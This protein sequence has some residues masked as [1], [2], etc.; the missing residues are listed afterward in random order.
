MTHRDIDTFAS[1]VEQYR[2]E[3]D[4][5]LEQIA[6]VLAALAS[7]DTPLLLT[8]AD[9]PAGFADSEGSHDHSRR[10][11]RDRSFGRERRDENTGCAGR[12]S[13]EGRESEKMETFRIEVGHAHKVKPANIVGAI[14]NET[15]LES[16]L[17]GRIEIF[18]EHS[19]VDMLAGMPAKIFDVLKN[20][21]IGG[22]RLDI[23]RLADGASPDDWPTVASVKA[24]APAPALPLK[25]ETEDRADVKKSDRA[26]FCPEACE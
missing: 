16:R 19:T 4:V 5:P 25:S 12:R 2:K 8:G 23:S 11:T 13:G 26:R 24:A 6:A 18:D 15:G 1:L 17:I 10:S 20:V 22:R 9:R 7:G 21:R 14:A 3:N